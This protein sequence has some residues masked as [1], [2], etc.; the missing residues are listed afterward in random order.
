M[1]CTG[2]FVTKIFHPNVSKAGEI[3]VNVLKK[4]WKPDLGLRHV[5]LVIR[6]LLVEPFP[7]S[8]LN[9]EA[10]KLLLDDYEDYAKHARLMTNIHAQP[11]K[12]YAR[13]FHAS[14]FQ[15]NFLTI[16]ILWGYCMEGQPHCYDSSSPTRSVQ[17]SRA[18]LGSRLRLQTKIC[19]CILLA[20]AQLT[21][22]P[23]ESVKHVQRAVAV[24]V[25]YRNDWVSK[26]T[27]VSSRQMPL[28][29]EAGANQVN[30]QDVVESIAEPSIKK[31]K[32]FEKGKAGAAAK[33]K[34]LKRL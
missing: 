34:S 20:A 4:D 33:K 27:F 17:E 13:H 28:S 23:Q 22:V 6:C 26:V 25:M 30:S 21:T 32:A 15:S 9:E 5:L 8:A 14:L 3:C 7:E 12:R 11:V 19:F 24:V 2:Y 10:G 1:L 29:A 31:P 16:C 18:R